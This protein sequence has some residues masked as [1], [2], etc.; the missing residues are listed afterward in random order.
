LGMN[1]AATDIFTAYFGS[2]YALYTILA[3]FLFLVIGLSWMF[4]TIK[5]FKNRS[6]DR[7]KDDVGVAW[8]VLRGLL[9]L[10]LLVAVFMSH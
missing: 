9:L 5:A 10:L 4:I 8:V 2:P 1:A 3:G 6:E 7:N